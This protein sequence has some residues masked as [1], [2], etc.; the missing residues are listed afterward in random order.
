MKL[1]IQIPCYNEEETLPVTIGELPKEI[2][3]IDIIETLLIDD[4]STDKS[5]EVARSLGV[6][7]IVELQ[8]NKGL[9]RTFMAGIQECI[10]L[11][12]DIIV[13]TDADNQ[14]N[15]EDIEKLVR[16]ILDKKVD[17]VIGTR[18]IERI[19]H[20]SPFKKFLQKV[21]SFMIRLLSST[22]TEDA[23]SGFRAFTRE[24]ALSLNVF[25]NY[26]YTL[27]TVIQSKSKGLKIASVP[28]RV[29]S[30]YRKSRLIK[31]IFDY[32][33]KSAFTMIRMFIIYRPFRFFAIIGGVLFGL[34]LI[35]WLR[36]L[37]FYFL[38]SGTGHIQS[39]IMAAI[40][41]II[42]FQTGMLAIIS[43][44]LAI[45]RK[46]VEDIQIRIKKLENK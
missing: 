37:Y 4:G 17:I 16:P 13:N 29:N 15:A 12:A 20:F 43:D 27:E 5:V 38:D 36:F 14:Y 23:P 30:T 33:R 8:N 28:I 19:K 31:N 25:D 39:L 42:G 3:G 9:A 35:I 22:G 11:E 32:V 41:M 2:S 45:N 34:G 18:P 7:H 46:L 1:I 40:L 6:D 26:T 24:A 10:K 44:L 21:G